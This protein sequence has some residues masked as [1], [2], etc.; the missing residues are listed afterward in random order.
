MNDLETAR[1]FCKEMRQ[2]YLELLSIAEEDK[3]D[4]NIKGTEYL[5][6]RFYN[7]RNLFC[8]FIGFVEKEINTHTIPQFLIVKSLCSIAVAGISIGYQDGCACAKR[9]SV[10]A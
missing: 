5:C 9:I 7:N 3:S 2:I 10:E 4:D 1:D 8:R 6:D